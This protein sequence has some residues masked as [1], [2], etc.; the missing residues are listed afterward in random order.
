[1]PKC[2]SKGV[3]LLDALIN[4]APVVVIISHP[5][6]NRGEWQVVSRGD[7]FKR[8]PDSQMHDDEIGNTDSGL[9]SRVRTNCRE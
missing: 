1:M 3:I 4:L 5:G 9:Q 7:L 8:L 6:M 2:F